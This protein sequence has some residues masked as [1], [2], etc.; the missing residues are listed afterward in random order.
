MG[1]EDFPMESIFKPTLAVVCVFLG[2]CDDTSQ[3]LQCSD[4]N[5]T[6]ECQSLLEACNGGAATATQTGLAT[7]TAQRM[8][9][10][11]KGKY[12]ERCNPTCQISE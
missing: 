12:A 9:A 2:A 3:R 11:L 10:C 7:S 5:L 1:A 4:P 8:T 6:A